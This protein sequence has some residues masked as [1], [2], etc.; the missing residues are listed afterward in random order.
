MLAKVEKASNIV[1]KS[2]EIAGAKDVSIRVLISKA[3]LS[4]LFLV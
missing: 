2:V 1:V 3:E 4:K